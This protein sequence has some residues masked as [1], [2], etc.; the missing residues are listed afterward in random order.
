MSFILPVKVYK[1]VNIM[2][3]MQEMYVMYPH[4]Q[5][6]QSPSIHFN[7]CPYTKYSIPLIEIH[8]PRAYT[9]ISFWR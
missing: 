3:Y 5:W 4:I 2:V 1:E 7:K 9:S 6:S 8:K